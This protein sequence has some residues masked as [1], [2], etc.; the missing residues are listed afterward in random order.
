MSA[1]ERTR[2]A[3]VDLDTAM[4]H[5]RLAEES[6]RPVVQFVGEKGF[7]KT[8]HLLAIAARFAGS[9]YLHLPE[10]EHR[11]IPTEGEPLL[12]DEAQRLNLWQR[13]R[14]FQSDRTLVLGTHR[15]F[16]RQLRRAGRCVLTLA[17]DRDT[18]SARV[19]AILNARILAVRRTEGPTPQ[20]TEATANRLFRQY[21]SDLRSMQHSLYEIFQQLRSIQDV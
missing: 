16:T 17:A 9:A 19:S 1:E 10:G 14:L 21:G 12:V 2:L 4:H 15:D 6:K 7:G 3:H 5:L 8:T 13:L 11:K 18:D 20:I